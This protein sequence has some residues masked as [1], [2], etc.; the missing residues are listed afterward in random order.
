MATIKDV[1]NK[2]GVSVAT[3]SHVINDTR[4]VS[5]ELTER[6]NEAMDEI[7]Y[8]PNAVAR[9]LKT[10]KTQTIGLIASDLSNPFFSTL[11][12]G[13]EDR[14]L[15]EDYSVIVCNTDETLDKERLYIDVLTQQKIDGLLIAPTG[16]DDEDLLNLQE[17]GVSIVFIDREIKGI[18]ADAVLSDNVTGA[19]TAIRHLVQLGHK[20]IGIILGLESVS[21]TRERLRGYKNVLKEKGIGYDPN[22]VKRGFSQVAGGIEATAEL[23]DLSNSPS[24]IFSANNLMT[25]GAMKEIQRRGYSC[26]GEISLVGFDDFE[27]ASTFKPK[28]TTIAQAPYEIGK[29]ATDALLNRIEGCSGEAKEVRIPTELK[30][31]ESTADFKEPNT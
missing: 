10:N 5:S 13:V 16:K 28:L 3:V 25:I 9:S 29:K 27:W 20:R 17:R 8:H 18:E 31:R 7:G 30:V 1:A 6:V 21:T 23:L 4:Y 26:P 15:E 11:L 2:A 22:L 14:A 12:R 19:S 24:A